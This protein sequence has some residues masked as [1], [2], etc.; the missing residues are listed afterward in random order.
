MT[1]DN[2]DRSILQLL[3]RNGRLPYSEIARELGSNEA[4]VRKRVE[5]LLRDGVCEII[6]VSNPYRL[7]LETHVLIGLEVDLR[8]LDAI[9]EQL[10][11][12]EELSYVACA[13]GEYD[14]VVVGVFESDAE[15]Y[16]FLSQ[17]LA[18]IE[19]IRKTYT[20]HLLRLMRR[21]FN[22]RIPASPPTPENGAGEGPGWSRG[23]NGSR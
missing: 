6:G 5:R 15:L 1:V 12:M 21:T 4:T 7:G 8:M 13:S 20:S 19:G 23:P 9:A 16:R 2:L 14:I 3:H 11:A 17:K 10:A 22:Y 18:A